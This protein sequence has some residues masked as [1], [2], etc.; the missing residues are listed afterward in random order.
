MDTSTSQ[1][2]I[3]IHTKLGEPTSFSQN[4]YSAILNVGHH[5]GSLS[6]YSPNATTPLVKIL[7]HKGPVR[8]SAVDRTGK[9]LITA[10]QDCQVSVFDIRTYR[11]LNKWFSRRP[12]TSL[13][14]SDRDLVAVG[15]GTQTSVWRGLFSHAKSDGVQEKV[16][17]PYLNWGGD[18][19]AI[20][21][22]R[23]VPF[24][25]L[26]G[27]GYDTG[28]SNVIVPGAG[29]ANPDALE[30]NIFETTKQRQEAEVKALLNKLRPEMISLNPDFVGN[31][32]L[33]SHETK[34]KEKGLTKETEDPILKLKNRARGKNSSLNKY[35]RKKSKGN[36]ID[37]R[38]ERIE[39]LKR[40]TYERTHKNPQDDTAEELGPALAR[41]IR[42]KA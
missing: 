29:E 2:I 21:C 31:L 28:V 18:G 24:E 37:E 6:M 11:E 23:W 17:S 27:V 20:E 16:K 12:A 42:K 7:A 14:I 40:Q 8:A 32:D 3:D 26:L 33:A 15:A 19:K 36:V 5:N 9:Y 30:T 34:Q 13:S 39:A 1:Q 38:R 22:L 4:P 10:G 41:F 25:D 35:L